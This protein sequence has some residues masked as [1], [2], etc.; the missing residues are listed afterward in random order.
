VNANGNITD[1][2][3]LNSVGFGCDEE[4]MRVVKNMPNWSAGMQNNQKVNVRMVLPI[5]FEIGN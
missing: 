2:Q 1:V 3:I 5:M 4:A